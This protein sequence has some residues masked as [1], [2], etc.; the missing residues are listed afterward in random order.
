[1]TSW[2]DHPFENGYL[3][4]NVVD[5][6]PLVYR[7]CHRVSGGFRRV[8]SAGPQLAATKCWFAPKTKSNFGLYLTCVPGNWCRPHGPQA[9]VAVCA[10]FNTI[11]HGPLT[12]EAIESTVY[13]SNDR[14]SC[15]QAVVQ[16]V[17]L[18][19]FQEKLGINWDG[20][21]YT[22]GSTAKTDGPGKNLFLLGTQ[23]PV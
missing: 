14:Q 7:F 9:E 8:Y 18:K 2:P 3:H 17:W 20:F 23:K 1:M 22:V 11:D 15:T 12:D 13:L 10:N 19:G 6:S 16:Q 4:L 5:G 21:T